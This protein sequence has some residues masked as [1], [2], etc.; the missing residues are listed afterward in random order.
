MQQ[1][2]KH[3]RLYMHNCEIKFECYVTA[4]IPA[5]MSAEAVLNI[6][7]AQALR[8]TQTTMIL[9]MENF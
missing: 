2:Q 7:G 8:Y 5:D 9:S 6:W 1:I 4:D 3:Q